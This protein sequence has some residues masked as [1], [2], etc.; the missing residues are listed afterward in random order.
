MY[1]SRNYCFILVQTIVQWVSGKEFVCQC[2][3]AELAGWIPE[4]GRS[5][6]EGHGNPVQ[7]SCLENFMDRWAWKATVHGVSKSQTRLSTHVHCILNHICS[8]VGTDP[9]WRHSK[10]PSIAHVFNSDQRASQS[11]CQIKVSS[12]LLNADQG[13]FLGSAFHEREATSHAGPT[14]S[15]PLLPYPAP[16]AAIGLPPLV[17]LPNSLHLFKI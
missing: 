1:N 9:P 15:S 3:N 16:L 10:D 12:W 14:G 6:G 4:S 8:I 11:V 2:I 5:P 13:T 7:Y 17:D